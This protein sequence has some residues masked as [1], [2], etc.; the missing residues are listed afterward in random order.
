MRLI[1]IIQSR[2]VIKRFQSKGNGLFQSA[3]ILLAI[4][5]VADLFPL[6]VF[7]RTSFA[8]TILRLVLQSATALL[9]ITWMWI[10]LN[11]LVESLTKR[12]GSSQFTVV[13]TV[14]I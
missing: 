12:K 5:F 3:L 8:W 2:D 11:V 14:L 6:D 1:Q 13:R 7:P 10:V 4:S 9:L